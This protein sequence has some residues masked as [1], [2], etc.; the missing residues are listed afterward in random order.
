MVMGPRLTGDERV[1]MSNSAVALNLM[2]NIAS[3]RA[4]PF[5]IF[6]SQRICCIPTPLHSFLPGL[7]I[8][9]ARSAAATT[10]IKS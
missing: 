4:A 10:E 7:A 9:L 8:L 5:P 3:T 6:P 2:F 1:V